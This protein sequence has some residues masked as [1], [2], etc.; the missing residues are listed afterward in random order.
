MENEQAN[1]E[2]S[3]LSAQH[4]ER[5]KHRVLKPGENFGDFRVVKCLCAGLIVNYYHMQHFRDLHD[6]TVGIFHHRVAK[7]A[8][9]LKRLEALQ[10]NLQS[11]D[12]EGI[13]KIRDCA[14]IDE[15]ICIFMDPVRGQT[16]SQYF[17]AHGSPG[18]EGLGFETSTRML[19][20]LLGLL[21]YAHAQGLE[22]RDIDSDMVFVQED[23]S[24]RL[25]GL[26]VKLALG[27]DLF[28][29]IV[30]AAVSPLVSSKTAG[31]LNSFDIM[32][33]EHMAGV[34]EDSRVDIYC[35]GVVG[36]W[37]LTGHKPEQA[38]L[39][40]PT[41][42]V[43]DLPRRWD[44]FFSRIL[45]RDPDER[46]QSCKMALLALKE[47]DEEP[48]SERAGFIQRQIDRIPV[49]KGI[50]ARGALAARVYR[51]SV[52]GCVGLTLTA[53]AAF[54]L[55]VTFTEVEHYNKDIAQRVT[56]GQK[57]QLR[58]KVQPPI[59]QVIFNGFDEDFIVNDGL[60][61][62][63]VQPG[64]YELIVSAPH[65]MEQRQ[66]V[67]IS[68]FGDRE[69][70]ELSFELEPAW[71]DIQIRSEPGA[72]I[73]VVDTR[74]V[75]IEL[76]FTDA[77]GVF[78]LNQGIFAGTYEVIVKKEGYQSAVLKDQK[79]GFG[80][81]ALIEAPLVPLPSSVTVRTNP[82]GAR[83]LIN[84]R[85]VGLSPLLVDDIIASDQ[86]LIVAQLEN[87]RSM[88]RRV[89]IKAGEDVVVDFGA[90]TPRSAELKL[91]VDFAGLTAEAH[92]PL[93]TETVVV[94]GDVRYPY[95]SADL[96][97]VPVGEYTIRV[98]HPQYISKPLELSLEDRQVKQLKFTLQPRPGEVQLVLPKDLEARIRLNR[99]AI[100][101]P[102]ERVSIPANESV[103]FELRMQNH[104]TMV[105]SFELAPN[106]QVVWK[107]RPV[108]IPGPAA[109]QRWTMP[110][111][112]MTF[113]WVPPGRFTMGSPM[114]EQGRL[115]TEGDATQI[116]FTQGY[117][118]GVYEVSQTEFRE[119]MARN[120]SEYVGANHP[121]D[122]VRWQD[123]NDFCKRL[124]ETERSA[125]RLPPGYVYRLPT[126]AEWEY[127]ARAGTSTPFHF[128]EAADATM[129][130]FR[131]IY[132]RDWE[133]GKGLS[134]TYG[135]VAVGS[136]APNAYGIFDMHG[137]VSEWTVDAFNGRLPGGQLTDPAPRVDGKRLT[138]RG[139]SWEDFA[140]KA[141]S[142]VREDVRMDAR[143]DAIG[144]RVFLAPE[145]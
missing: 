20:Q 24:I 22:H 76:G 118:A 144:F 114:A 90:L 65:H 54:F 46:F 139:G 61:E 30:S 106:E 111:L 121:V 26:G 50:L 8:K 87:Y 134:A 71:T 112:G 138:I 117:W 80:E 34:P 82:E 72:S 104:L 133:E 13:P 79:L 73:S 43:A 81:V 32:S 126:E 77:A 7:D 113:V 103:E 1:P 85:E 31:R 74:D 57:P 132:P 143:S 64:E 130:N 16:L 25:L 70:A 84:N 97:S 47:S 98:E 44:D 100:P 99:E 9:F 23:G 52:I 40:L 11:L 116:T 53:L 122:S 45:Q 135:S 42:L 60:L 28:E 92:R 120:P 109:G 48:E 41:A 66:S 95:G 38:D 137:N 12:H 37:L 49:P 10:K 123:A 140:V 39:Q 68:G 56:E 55:R 108:P 6:V 27:A 101:F 145:K 119:I 102:G 128:G 14:E 33:P 29:S 5:L 131:G 89:E 88:G 69:L 94:M 17:D 124:T 4:R 127:A 91:E 115:P 105:R 63:R 62:L 107:V 35:A 51:L 15:R 3:G 19:A 93:L 36:Y 142:A 83:I 78:F 125:G 136:Y 141:R 110:Y 18:K 75:E 21:G 96:Q 67:Q 129:G 58:V 86:Y 2:E 59:A